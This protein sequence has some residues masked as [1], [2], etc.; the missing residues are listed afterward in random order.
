[1]RKFLGV[2]GS[3]RLNGNT[4][5]LVDS[6]LEAARAEGAETETL[7]LKD[8]NIVQHLFF[9]TNLDKNTDMPAHL[10]RVKDGGVTAD[11]SLLLKLTDPSKARRRGEVY[12]L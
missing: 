12:H 11:H 1:M 6:I 10:F 4:H 7:F 2:V 8:L 9:Q 3:P 5:I